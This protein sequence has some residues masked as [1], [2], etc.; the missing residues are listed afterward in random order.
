[1][2]GNVIRI[3]SINLLVLSQSKVDGEEI[4]LT[5]RVQEVPVFLE[6]GVLSPIRST[7]ERIWWLTRTPVPLARSSLDK[8][9]AIDEIQRETVQSILADEKLVQ[10]ALAVLFSFLQRS[11]GRVMS[12][13]QYHTSFNRAAQTLFR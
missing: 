6:A 7:T 11:L 8:A 2:V 3:G 5:V 13:E 12:P 4:F 9:E 10:R 1:M